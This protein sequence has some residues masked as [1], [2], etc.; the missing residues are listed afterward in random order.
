M[1]GD[2]VCTTCRELIAYRV[3]WEGTIEALV[4]SEYP[5][6]RELSITMT[7]ALAV[8]RKVCVEREMPSTEE[9]TALIQAKVSE[10]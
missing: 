9:I 8:V 5:E 10:I 7:T 2:E 4:E 1:S 3:C 6:Y